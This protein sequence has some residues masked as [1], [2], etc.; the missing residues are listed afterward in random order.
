MEV[1]FINNNNTNLNEK[2]LK[3]NDWNLGDFTILIDEK[4]SNF[5]WNKT[6]F[7]YDWCYGNGTLKNPY[8]IENVTF[9]TDSPNKSIIIKNSLVYFIVRNCIFNYC[10]EGIG[11]FNVSN[12]LI[13]NNLFLNTYSTSIFFKTC[14]NVTI[15][16]NQLTQV[17][18]EGIACEQCNNITIIH[19]TIDTFYGMNYGVYCYN[20]TYSKIMN[21]TIKFTGGYNKI[22]LFFSHHNYLYN[23][24]LLSSGGDGIHTYESDYNIISKNL[25][26]DCSWGMFLERNSC[27]NLIIN[28]IIKQRDVGIKIAPNCNFNLVT[29]NTLEFNDINRPSSIY[30][31]IDISSS[32]YNN[33]TFNSIAYYYYG[34][35]LCCSNYS[36]VY[37]N[38]LYKNF[39]TCI[40][41]NDCIGNVI[42]NNNCIP[43]DK[44]TGFN[45]MIILIIL[46]SSIIFIKKRKFI[47]VP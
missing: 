39:K 33:I 32:N 27:Y 40:Y 19:N 26:K 28:N 45:Y 20:L 8:I 2:F 14:F 43:I 44:I 4:D 36:Y 23:N 16:A 21:N 42:F 15:S 7:E 22:G 30:D 12:G 25:I 31:G 5:S 24:S 1:N 10:F 35:S 34:I 17:G 18:Y 38:T 47:V 13:L 37:N 3:Q 11:F 29:N 41:E 9:G 46:L 6:A